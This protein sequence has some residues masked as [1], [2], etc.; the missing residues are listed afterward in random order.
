MTFQKPVPGGIRTARFGDSG[1]YWTNKH[2]GVDYSAMIGTAVRASESGTVTVANWFS[3]A[4]GNLVAIRHPNGTVTRYA[5]LSA[6]SV[7]V[8]DAVSR[9]D[10]IAAVGNTGNVTGPHVH[11]EMMIG[12]KF[13]DPE[14]YLGTDAGTPGTGTLP[15]LAGAN[16]DLGSGFSRAG[17]FVGGATLLI[18]ATYLV[19]KDR[20]IL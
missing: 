10:K 1:P 6:F 15:N 17:I 5:H 7:R 12:G 3:D 16:L 4:Y 20:G 11:F 14:L 2:T 9:G 18:L 19:L 8:G 13:V